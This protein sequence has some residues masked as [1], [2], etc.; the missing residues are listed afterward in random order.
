MASR[1]QSITLY[2]YAWDIVN[3]VGKTGD[4]ANHTLYLVKDGGTPTAPTN[5]PA[6]ISSAE[7]PGWYEVTLIS[8]E[9]TANT[10]LLGG[11]SSS[12]GIVICGT[13]VTLE[14]LPTAA[15]AASGGLP[16]FGTGAGQINVD[17]AGNVEANIVKIAGTASAGAAGYVG[18]DW[19]HVNSAST[20]VNLSGTTIATSQ[21]VA[22]VSGSVGSVS[23]AV[24]SVIGNVG[25]S[26]AGSVASV[27]GA[28]GSVTGNV[29]GNVAGSTASVTAPVA[30]SLAQALGAARGL[31]MQSPT[32]H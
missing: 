19:G 15:P 1:A 2:Y 22:S 11:V 20:A 12:S 13:Q 25:G 32:H 24:G 10:V 30:V 3:S 17:G 18:V 21:V 6:E 26:I 8:A 4:V 23:G 31:S 27:T 7:M 28:V 5:A 14:Q 16:T 9:A 29:G